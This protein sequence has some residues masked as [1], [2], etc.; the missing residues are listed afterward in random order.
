[1]TVSADVVNQALQY[2]GN[3]VAISTLN[4]GSPAGNAAGVIYAPTWQMVAR[5]MDPDF[6]R[7]TL[8]L[9]TVSGGNLPPGIAYEYSYPSDCLRLRALAPAAG[10]YDIYDP[11]LITGNV[12]LDVI[13]GTPQK[14]IFTNQQNAL[15]VYTSN[16]FTENQWDYAFLMA[17]VRQLASPLSMALQGRPDYARE[18]LL[19][20]QQYEQQ[21]EL[22]DESSTGGP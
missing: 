13:M 15:A 12:A 1:M 9:A 20:A 3:Q 14:V 21:A 8:P 6:A 22:V 2:A 11:Q 5:M 18:L 16:D 7:R 19:T 10:S 4:D 17:V